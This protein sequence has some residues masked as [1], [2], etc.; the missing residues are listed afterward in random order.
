MTACWINSVRVSIVD[1]ISALINL[2]YMFSISP[3]TTFLF[4]GLKIK[5][6]NK[7]CDVAC[8]RC[9]CARSCP[10]FHSIK[11]KEK[12]SISLKKII[13]RTQLGF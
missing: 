11:K 10:L 2:V 6:T 9:G 7:S 1:I 13:F 4:D 8:R 3:L 12:R 5:V